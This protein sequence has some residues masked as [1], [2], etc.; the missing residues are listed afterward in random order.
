MNGAEKILRATDF[1]AHKHAGQI[2]KGR[3]AHPYIN[4]PIGVAHLVATVGEVYDA[5]ILVAG[6]LHDTGEDCGVTFEELAG[7]FG[8]AAAAIVIELTDEK[9]LPDIVRKQRQIEN[10]PNLSERA[11][12][13]KLADK[14]DN[15]SELVDDTPPDWPVEKCREYVEWG[16]SVV[17]GLRGTNAPLEKLFDQV[18]ERARSKFDA[19]T[20]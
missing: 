11:K 18:V 15:I 17:D 1:A 19:S 7:L 8:H 10:A 3:S 6:I 5:D 16:V 12:V 13:V 2:R 4:H 9:S 14:I 20:T